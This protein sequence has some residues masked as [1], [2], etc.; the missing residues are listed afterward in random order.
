MAERQRLLNL[1]IRNKLI[2]EEEDLGP[3]V[4]KLVQM[5]WWELMDLRN[6]SYSAARELCEYLHEFGLTHTELEY[7]LTHWQYGKYRVRVESSS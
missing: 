3:Q 5:E 6:F 7:H 4:E 2:I 1:L